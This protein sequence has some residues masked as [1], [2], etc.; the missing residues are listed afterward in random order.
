MLVQMAIA[1]A[2]GLGFEF[3]PPEWFTRNDLSGYQP[4]GLHPITPGCYSDDTQMALANAE[5]MLRHG[6]EA[7]REDFAEAYVQA[8]QRDPRLGYAKGFHALLSNVADGAELLAAIR[9]NSNR[10]GA[11]MRAAPIGLLHNLDDVLRV[12]DVQARVTHDTPGGVASA[13]AVALAVHHLVH[14]GGQLTTLRTRIVDVLGAD[15][16]TPWDGGE[17]HEDGMAIANAAITAAESGSGLADILQTA[18]S[19]RGDTDTVA[20]IAVA[21]AAASPGTLN[22]LPQFL[23]EGAENGTW[24]LTYLAGVDEALSGMVQGF[25]PYRPQ[26]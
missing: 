1:D 7:T 4:H 3:R 14:E 26:R 17:V 12:A 8:F 15:W 20:A 18:V 11:A 2:Y 6:R 13:Q 24:G 9:P 16:V 23:V 19:Y 22:D 5:V 25:G 21:I 10:G